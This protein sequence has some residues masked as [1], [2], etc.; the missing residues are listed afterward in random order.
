FKS[1]QV[2]EV[3]KTYD[4]AIPTL[5]NHLGYKGTFRGSISSYVKEKDGTHSNVL[6][7]QDLSSLGIETKLKAFC[8]K[9]VFISDFESDAIPAQSEK[10]QKPAT[11]STGKIAPPVNSA[12]MAA[13]ASFKK[14]T[15]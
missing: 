8:T 7:L 11:P 13:L 9:G 5:G 12:A 14:K 1:E 4:L 15:S 3:G 6:A 2:L 10:K